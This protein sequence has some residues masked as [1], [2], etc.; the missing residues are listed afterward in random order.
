MHEV[1]YCIFLLI[2]YQNNPPPLT[3]WFVGVFYIDGPFGWATEKLPPYCPCTSSPE[4]VN[5]TI[6]K[7]LTSNLVSKVFY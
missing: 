6:L 1:N 2:S 4:V 7:Y 5:S 3:E